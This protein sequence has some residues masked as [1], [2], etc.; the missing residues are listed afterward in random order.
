MS[1]Q[2]IF[3]QNNNPSPPVVK[4]E[5]LLLSIKNENGEP[6]Y[7]TVEDAL[8]GLEHSQNFISTLL[9]EKREKE[10]EL[11]QLRE[12]S[13]K[14]KS[15]DDVLKELT[16]RNESNPQEPKSKTPPVGELSEETIAALVRKELE[17]ANTAAQANLNVS[18]V[19]NTL[20]TKF[21][22]KAGEVLAAKAAELGTTPNDLGELAKKNPKLVLSLFNVSKPSVTPTSSSINLPSNPAPT[23]IDPP[24]KSL[25]LGAT[26]NDQKDYMKKIKEHVYKK[27]DVQE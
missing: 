26:S 4:P 24:S 16:A 5:D 8:K 25:L 13:Q 9:N 3:N 17:Q 23:A 1:D 27:F 11:R 15:I 20:I 10:E 7:K 18:E 19:Q 12:Q 2:D 21:G 6:K 14:Q 22:D